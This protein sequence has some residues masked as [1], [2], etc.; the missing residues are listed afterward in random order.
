MASPTSLKV[1]QMCYPCPRTGVTH[2]S[3]LNT[4]QG[5]GKRQT[6]AD[7][8]SLFQ[9]ELLGRFPGLVH[10]FRQRGILQR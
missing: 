8:R 2:V 4:P 3:G 5:G 7:E 1:R 10:H 9:K 6:D